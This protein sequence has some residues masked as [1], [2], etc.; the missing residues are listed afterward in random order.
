[1]LR[2]KL[3]DL[4]PRLREQAVRQL[5]P[6]QPPKKVRPPITMVKKSG[7][8]E[9]EKR[10][11][12]EFLGGKGKYEA[13]TLRLPG[14]SKYTPDFLYQKPCH[15]RSVVLVEVKG[16]YR[17]HSQARAATAF[18]TACALFPEFTFCWAEQLKGGKRWKVAFYEN[19]EQVGD[20]QEGTAAEILGFEVDQCVDEGVDESMREG[21]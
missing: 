1:M 15:P 21:A 18:K 7:Q 4:P 8:S 19:G 3:E 10:F 16:S 9:A 20:C 14:G 5:A 11:N 17:L 13:L 12:A 6:K 2:F